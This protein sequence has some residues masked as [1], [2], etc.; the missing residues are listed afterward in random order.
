MSIFD[1]LDER[2]VQAEAESEQLHQEYAIF[3]DLY[4]KAQKTGKDIEYAT[5]RESWALS[6]AGRASA[7]ITALE[8]LKIL[9]AVKDADIA[10]LKAELNEILHEAEG[11]ELS[12]FITARLD[13]WAK[14]IDPAFSFVEWGDA[15]EGTQGFFP[16]FNI[17]FPRG[18]WTPEM[19]Q[20][21]NI[22]SR[23]LRRDI[24]YVVD[25]RTTKEG[26]GKKRSN[27]ILSV[28]G[29][30]MHLAAVNYLGRLRHKR[31]KAFNLFTYA[32]ST[33]SYHGG[34]LSYKK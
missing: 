29:E 8:S 1:N 34:D 30:G 12:V 3:E 33:V 10:S 19:M 11:N 32:I 9:E 15:K 20:K 21:I 17:H 5:I 13:D 24:D 31:P 26:A 18:K 6:A 23:A 28:T 4:W 2:I 27:Y 25:F 22:F 14:S 7:R 16:V